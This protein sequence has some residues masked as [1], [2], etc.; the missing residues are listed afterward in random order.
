MTTSSNSALRNTFIIMMEMIGR[1]FQLGVLFLVI[2]T[3]LV[4]YDLRAGVS[5]DLS[6]A[7]TQVA[8]LSAENAELEAA[9]NSYEAIVNEQSAML[10][11]LDET[12]TWEKTKGWF[13]EKYNGFFGDEEEAVEEPP[14]DM[15]EEYLQSYTAKNS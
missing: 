8:E 7:Q 13:S 4:M 12:S 14:V 9:V 3:G 2:L 1:G 5:A 10:L 11:E 15:D 6:A